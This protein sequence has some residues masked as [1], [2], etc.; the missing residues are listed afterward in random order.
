MG[1]RPS[2]KKK[3]ICR[4]SKYFGE[5]A[6]ERLRRKMI[7][8]CLEGEKTKQNQKNISFEQKS[9]MMENVLNKT[10]CK[11]KLNKNFRE[12]AK[13]KARKKT[14]AKSIIK[15]VITHIHRFCY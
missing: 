3:K 15:L 1:K 11:H 5:K 6:G 9:R 13:G 4:I 2:Q 12:I 10:N 8:K 14:P 7:H